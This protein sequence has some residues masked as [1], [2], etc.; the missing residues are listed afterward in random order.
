MISERPRVVV[1]DEGRLHGRTALATVRALGRAGYA[2]VVTVAGVRSL[3]SS[4]RWCTGVVPVPSDDAGWADAVTKAGHSAVLVVPAS[5]SAVA[6]L[7]LSGARLIDKRVVRERALAVGLPVPPEQE[8]ADHQ[9]LLQHADSLPYPVV[10]KP[11][12]RTSV[13]RTET[14]RVADRRALEDVPTAQPLVVQSFLAGP[15]LSVTVLLLRGRLVA[16]VHQR[17]DRIWPTGSGAA[18]ASVTVEPDPQLEDKVLQLVAGH[19]GVAQVQLIDGHVIDVNPRMYASLALAER[20]GVN[21]PAL[22]CAAVSDGLP[23]TLPVRARVGVRYRWTDA[24]V[25]AVAAQLRSGHMRLRDGLAALAPH[26]D[27]AHSIEDWRDPAPLLV[28]L[29]Y[30]GQ[31]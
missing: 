27:T 16:A 11:A 30:S 29:R 10:V 26:R 20:S 15:F 5:D 7:G 22:W 18:S 8:Y 14:V 13:H 9:A 17:F 6:I 2:P 19:E 24:D 25:R 21:F 1:A 3:A 23:R 31:S 4:S 12:A 28:R